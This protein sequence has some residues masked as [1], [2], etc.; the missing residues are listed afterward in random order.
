MGVVL[1]ICSCTSQ[2]I[3]IANSKSMI[4]NNINNKDDNNNNN[5]NEAKV[6]IIDN[7]NINIIEEKSKKRISNGLENII[8][9][10]QINDADTY[11]KI[12]SSKGALILTPKIKKEKSSSRN[13]KKKKD[14]ISQNNSEN[15]EDEENID[16]N[17]KKEKKKKRKNSKHKSSEKNILE[18]DNNN[19]S[20]KKNIYVSE[21]EED[22]KENIEISDIIL[23]EIVLEEKP[24]KIPRDKRKKIKGR[25]SI[26]IIIIGYNEVGKSSFCIRFVENKFEDFYIPSIGVENYSKIIAYNDRNYKLNFSVIWGEAKI[27]KQEKLLDEADFF[28]LIYDITKVKSF[29]KINIYLKQLKKFLLLYDKEGKSPN[30]CLA[31][32]KSD[33]EGERKVQIENINKCIEKYGIKHFDISVKTAKNINSLIQFFVSIFDKIANSNK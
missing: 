20:S 1:E 32:N 12:T 29:N 21:E 5:L 6:E 16:K 7:N 4:E 11:N 2:Q 14:K 17:D 9:N 19:C 28:L 13:S 26:N 27:K 33:L 23:S 24:K 31:G 10:E 30:F 15:K 22:F 8:N 25:N 3:I 18:S